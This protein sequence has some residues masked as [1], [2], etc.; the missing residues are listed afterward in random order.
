VSSPTSAPATPDRVAGRTVLVTGAGNGLGRSISLGLVARGARVL[1]VARRAEALEAVAAEAEGLPG[2]ARVATADVSDPASVEA[3]AAELADESV[4]VLVN[5]AGVP[6]PVAPL[7]EISPDEW[8]DVFDVNVRG[9]YLMCRAFIPGMVSRGEGDVINVASVSGKRPLTR[10]TPYAASKMAV[11][12]LTT[13]LAF[14]VGPLGVSVNSLSP[15]PVDG[16]RMQRNFTMEA[17]RTGTTYAEAEEAY[18]S[19]A[20]LHRMLTEEEVA[21]AVVAMLHMPGLCA[22][23]IDLSAG[24]V[25][26]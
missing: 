16:P 20:A 7:L 5:N 10:R 15:G 6:G 14:E 1:L 3:L 12:G 17:E 25:A 11:I 9:V 22:A 26:R 13:T 19:R 18:V 2:S 8:D 23:D 21:D 4:E 24:M